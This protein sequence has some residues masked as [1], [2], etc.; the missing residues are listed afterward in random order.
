MQEIIEILNKKLPMCPNV[1]GREKYINTSV[2]VPLLNLKKEIHFLFQ[3]RSSTI[4]QGGEIC[5]LGGKFDIK[6]DK[7]LKDT[8]IRECEEEIGLKKETLNI[9]G[10]IDT[11][12][13]P[14]G[15][16]VD[17]FIAIA[18]IKNLNKLNIN[19]NEVEKVF[20]LPLNFF[21]KNR[22]EKYYV[23]LEIQPFE[24]DKNGEKR[25]LFPAEK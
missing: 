15:V 21:K 18:N 6:K 9:L 17:S 14:M 13:A 5:F 12:V 2:L 10:Q 3:I 25:I 22:P 20:T 24:L 16:T 7:T 19:K 11:I 23:K 8:A 1:Q 4:N